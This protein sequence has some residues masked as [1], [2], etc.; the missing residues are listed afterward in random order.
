MKM[1]AAFLYSAKPFFIGYIAVFLSTALFR[2]LVPTETAFTA[3]DCLFFFL[4]S[5]LT[6]PRR[7]D[8][9]LQFGISREKQYG[10]L[11]GL[12]AVAVLA[13]MLNGAAQGVRAAV[14]AQ[15]PNLF[16]ASPLSTLASWYSVPV[17]ALLYSAAYAFGNLAALFAGALVGMLLYRFLRAGSRL[18]IFLPIVLTVLPIGSWGVSA[19]HY[20]D[21]QS[22]E[23]P[24]QAMDSALRWTFQFWKQ[25]FFT[26]AG[27]EDGAAG[28]AVLFLI[29]VPLFYTV[30][31]A[32]LCCIF[33]R[34]LPVRRGLNA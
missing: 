10:I 16:L 22:I 23:I 28:D 25:T 20:R 31:F 17:C 12:G 27:A 18:N 34:N 6:F 21:G 4:A 9:F 13:G 30:I 3:V 7:T 15:S 29:A 33:L 11:W 19:L 32:S 1:K 5:A 26:G 8:L 2:F 24:P 14:Y